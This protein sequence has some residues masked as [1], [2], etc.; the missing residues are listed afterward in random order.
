[1]KVG[2]RENLVVE[3]NNTTQDTWKREI[4]KRGSRLAKGLRRDAPLLFS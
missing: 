2:D 1:M 3:I 4:V